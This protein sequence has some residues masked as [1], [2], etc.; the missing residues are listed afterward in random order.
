MR[1][2]CFFGH[3]ANK[4]AF[5]TF[6]RELAEDGRRNGFEV[7]GMNIGRPAKGPSG[8][9][10]SHLPF[11]TNPTF[12]G[13]MS[14]RADDTPASRAWSSIAEFEPKSIEKFGLATVNAVLAN[15]YVYLKEYFSQ[16]KPEIVILGHQF[17][18]PY[19]VALH[20]CSEL[21]IPV[22]FNHPGVL[23]G[24]MCFEGAG[25]MAESEL[26]E[27]WGDI[28]SREIS[29]ELLAASQAF[30]RHLRTGLITRPG[31]MN[32]TADSEI[33]KVEGLR[34]K[35]L[36][37]LY[38]GIAD[39]RTG[40]QPRSYG[41]CSLHS[42][43]VSSSVDGL[44]RFVELSEK[45]NFK[46]IYKAHPIEAE[47]Y[48]ECFNHPNVLVVKEITINRLLDHCDAFS[49]IC[50]SSAY[51][52]VLKGVPTL[53]LGRMQAS[54]CPFVTSASSVEDLVGFI[55]SVKDRDIQISETDV[56]QHVAYLLRD[57]LFV[58]DPLLKTLPLRLLSDFWASIG[59][60]ARVPEMDTRG[61]RQSAAQKPGMKMYVRRFAM[62]LRD[63]RGYGFSSALSE[64][65]EEGRFLLNC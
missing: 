19:Q 39:Y 63:I 4:P 8:L 50:S 33:E 31:K 49:T 17:A 43:W 48:D 28:T 61:M 47:T 5:E 15:L 29:G 45:L 35:G 30:I 27:R 51:E 40:V 54:L 38:A 21:R 59:D 44:K 62:L 55:Q 37:V 10:M 24:T 58:S 46:I 20:V 60:I 32:T 12:Y 53:L 36:V 64:L 65:K 11:P 23:N 14:R 57:Y 25:Q 2:I 9:P 1:R 42:S 6:F 3:I 22:V 13:W 18:A 41:R 56:V 34:K 16:L 52:A 26:F 7:T